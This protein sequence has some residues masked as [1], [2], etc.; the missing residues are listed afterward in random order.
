MWNW[1]VPLQ[2]WSATECVLSS[3]NCTFSPK[4]QFSA[5]VPSATQVQEGWKKVGCFLDTQPELRKAWDIMLHQHDNSQMHRF[6][7]LL[8]LFTVMNI[9][10]TF[11]WSQENCLPTTLLPMDL[12]MPWQVVRVYASWAKLY[13]AHYT[14]FCALQVAWG[15]LIWLQ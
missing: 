4:H 1:K 15:D 2:L 7:T 14:C 12:D 9:H 5:V 13:T 11:L 6:F 8:P 3:S 10:N